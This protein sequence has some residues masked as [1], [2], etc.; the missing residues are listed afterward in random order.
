MTLPP[1]A[2]LRRRE[3]PRGRDHSDELPVG[4]A[5]LL[6]AGLPLVRLPDVA[7]VHIAVDEGH[8]RFGEARL[9]DGGAVILHGH[10]L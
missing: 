10:S 2:D 9:K 5:V 4:E 7:R 8:R 3:L 1:V 6:I